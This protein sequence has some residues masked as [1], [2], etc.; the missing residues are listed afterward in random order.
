[1]P[2]IVRI[3]MVRRGKPIW[4]HDGTVSI[5]RSSGTGPRCCSIDTLH[6]RETPSI[7]GSNLL[8]QLTPP[9]SRLEPTR[10]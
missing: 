8:T 9:H 5:V 4:S 10:N 2:D 7:S 6:A 1:M 3:S